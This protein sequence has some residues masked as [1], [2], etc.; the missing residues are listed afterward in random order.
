M[1]R[2]QLEHL[3]RA[4]ADIADD[5][6]LIILGS[7]AILGQF[8]NAPPE[9][10]VSADLDLYPKNRPDRADLI[11]GSIGEL[12]PFHETFGYYAHAAGPTTA[13]LP[14]GWQERL[15]AV[16]GPNTRGA[17]G[18]C[19]EIH[20]LAISKGIAGRDKDL[21]Y[22]SVLAREGLARL[23]TL[24]ERLVE[25]DVPPAVR[26]LARAHLERLFAAG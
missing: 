11:E 25:T 16:R 26:E 22:L 12:S 23:D 17:T 2:E 7:Q 3:I 14:A 20:D 24:R 9:L 1:T 13:V 15:I 4:A 10:C 5:D 19:L 21:E 8:P 18:W 6:E